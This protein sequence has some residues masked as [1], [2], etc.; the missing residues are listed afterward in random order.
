MYAKLKKKVVEFTSFIYVHQYHVTDLSIINT[1]SFCE[2]NICMGIFK[3]Q[4]KIKPQTFT[5]AED[6]AH[7]TGVL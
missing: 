4:N 5:Q 7:D 1:I 6:Q 2:S 3:T